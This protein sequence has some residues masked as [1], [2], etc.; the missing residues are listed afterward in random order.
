MDIVL[1]SQSITYV[2]NRVQPGEGSFLFSVNKDTK[3]IT[4]HPD[5]Y[6]I[7]KTVEEYGLDEKYLQ[8]NLCGLITVSRKSYYILSGIAGSEYL[9][10]AIS[11]GDLLKERL[12]LSGAAALATFILLNLISITLYA[13]QENLIRTVQERSSYE[14]LMKNTPEY[15]A[16]GLLFLF[17]LIG[18][19]GVALYSKMD[20]SGDTGIILEYV[21]NGNWERG[22]NAF[23]L[24][25]SLVRLSM[26]GIVIVLFRRMMYLLS[27]ILPIRIG[28]IIRMLTSLF[29]YGGV[30][31]ILYLCFVDFGMPASALMASA[32][33]VSVV[34]GI[35]ANSLMGDIIA[36]MF[37]LMEGHV[38][39]GDTIEVDGFVGIVQEMGIRVTKLYYP[40]DDIV[41]IIPNRDVQNVIHRSMYPARI[42]INYL[43]EYSE[44]L[45]RVETLMLE[46][47]ERIPKEV[48]GVIGEPVYLGVQELGNDGVLLKI[49]IRGHEM[50]RLRLIRDVNR[51][52]YLM[53]NRNHISV[54]YPQVTVH[55]GAETADE[56]LEAE[57]KKTE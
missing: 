32:G 19:A 54:P 50:D 56:D 3:R 37:L 52:I 27:G 55:H 18:A 14:R 11:D 49:R 21:L 29:S 48:E 42:G 2:L 7:G 16:F 45:E 25:S 12:P 9:F 33:V 22:V 44:D 6:V 1:D 17:I 24:T 23:A 15:K 26:G 40:V 35:G 36:G 13:Q 46:E 28:T 20:S 4:Y 10:T 47:L 41:K 51:Q 38:Q 39:V 53:F 31:F 30:F 34:L 57:E 43:I 8:D 5:P